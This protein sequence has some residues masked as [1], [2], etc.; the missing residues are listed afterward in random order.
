MGVLRFLVLLGVLIGA[1]T[2]LAVQPDEMLSDPTLEARA[3]LLSRELRCLVCQNQSIDDS[4][5]PLAHDLRILVRERLKAGDD[6]RQVLDYLVARYGKFVLLKPR[7]ELQT[8]L[9]WFT[10]VLVLMAGAVAA[11]MAVRRRMASLAVEPRLSA[12]E[13]ARINELMRPVNDQQ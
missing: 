10:P 3:R 12:A 13:E 7:F 11:A 2:A 4:E 6:D 5:A 8:V 1:N 9:L